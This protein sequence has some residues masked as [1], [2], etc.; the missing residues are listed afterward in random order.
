MLLFLCG[1]IL[2]LTPLPPAPQPP[3]LS[4]SVM[5]WVSDDSAEPA[6]DFS[7]IYTF[8]AGIFEPAQ[9]ALGAGSAWLREMRPVDRVTA[10]T[11]VQNLLR[12]LSSQ[13]MWCA[14]PC[15][16]VKGAA[17]VLRWRPIPSPRCLSCRDEQVWLASTGVPTFLT[18]SGNSG[19]VGP[20]TGASAYA[21]QRPQLEGKSPN[22]PEQCA[23]TA[24][25][26]ALTA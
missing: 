8:L 2:V 4:R 21:L 22:Q 6:P 3:A 19:T 18:A 16:K 26:N 17:V 12:N 25:A 7:A 1:E 23:A 24:D 13:R 20:R 14:P 10:L 9:R 11:L 15:C 5:P